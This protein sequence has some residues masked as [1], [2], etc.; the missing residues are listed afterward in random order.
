MDGRTHCIIYFTTYKIKIK[1]NIR[2]THFSQYSNYVNVSLMLLCPFRW[3]FQQWQISVFLLFWNH[4]Y[5]YLS[6]RQT[7]FPMYVRGKLK[8]AVSLLSCDFLLSSVRTRTEPTTTRPSNHSNPLLSDRHRFS[9]APS[10]YAQPLHLLYF[11]VP[12]W[13]SK[14]ACRYT[15]FG[16]CTCLHLLSFLSF[17]CTKSIEM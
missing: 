14:P 12:H 8:S 15:G 16:V 10:P 5:L 7:F 9:P 2:K 4:F 1:N 3:P 11:L 6:W 13:C 17:F